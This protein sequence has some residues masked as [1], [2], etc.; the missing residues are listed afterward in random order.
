[1]RTIALTVCSLA[2]PYA[3]QAASPTSEAGATKT[4]ER[5]IL[6]VGQSVAKLPIETPRF[7][8]MWHR[9]GSRRGCSA[10]KT[11]TL[12]ESSSTAGASSLVA[13]A[14][15]IAWTINVS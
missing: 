6:L 2:F 4:L 3:A 9:M 5:A 10:V 15:P 11:G 7:L 1:M 8:Q 13:P 14:T 12:N